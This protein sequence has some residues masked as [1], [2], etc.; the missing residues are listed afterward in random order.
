MGNKPSVAANPGKPVGRR[1]DGPASLLASGQ[2]ADGQVSDAAL[3]AELR[4][5]QETALRIAAGVDLLS[6]ELALEQ[7]LAAID[8]EALADD[9]AGAG[10]GLVGDGDDDV[11]LNGLD[12]EELAELEGE[13]QELERQVLGQEATSSAAAPAPAAAPAAT[14]TTAAAS[15][16]AV[17]AA[18]ASAAA[19]EA[20]SAST[21]AAAAA[22]A[23]AAALE[24][25]SATAAAAA[26][27]VT[28]APADATEDREQALAHKEVQQQEV[29]E[30]MEGDEEERPR[31][32]V[33]A[34]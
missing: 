14:G 17:A 16:A 10:A 28:T 32:P 13:L 27:E 7:K 4:A 11:D 21:A 2:Q 24:A 31:L 3:E 15:T 30:G 29:A 19:L 23:S 26:A 8:D 25:K 18:A 5:A 1:A 12:S 34:G 9:V 22:A 33:L 20:K 6:E